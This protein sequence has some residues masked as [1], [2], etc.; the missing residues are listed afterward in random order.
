MH[1]KETNKT[2]FRSHILSDNKGAPRKTT[3]YSQFEIETQ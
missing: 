2:Q 1:I 3:I